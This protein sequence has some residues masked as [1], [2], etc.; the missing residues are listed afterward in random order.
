MLSPDALP[1]T[2]VEKTSDATVLL[3]AGGPIARPSPATRYGFV[4]IEHESGTGRSRRWSPGSVIS[5]WLAARSPR[6]G[7]GTSGAIPVLSDRV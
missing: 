6:S 4:A 3:A 1:A 2:A 7:R 5:S